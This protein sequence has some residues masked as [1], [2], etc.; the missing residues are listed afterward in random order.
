MSTIEEPKT[1]EELSKIICNFF[2]RNSWKVG[3]KHN[4]INIILDFGLPRN[5]SLNFVDNK[6][7]F[8]LIISRVRFNF[9]E[10]DYHCTGIEN[11]LG[12]FTIQYVEKDSYHS[13]LN[14]YFRD[15]LKSN[16]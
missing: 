9:G 10:Y 8:K 2:K 7:V 4:N 1:V 16:K 11:K 12:N 14:C 5:N 13:V 6:D 3:R 15:K